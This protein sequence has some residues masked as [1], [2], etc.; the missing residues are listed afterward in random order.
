MFITENGLPKAAYMMLLLQCPY[1][2]AI[3]IV[4]K[5]SKQTRGKKSF[6]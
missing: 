6:N 3:I 2:S 4:W 5:E 1:D